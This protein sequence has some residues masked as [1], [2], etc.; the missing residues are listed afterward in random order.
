[1]K[2][3]ALLVAVVLVLV[4]CST[5]ASPV[6]PVR[7]AASASPDAPS[8]SA[9]ITFN[10]ENDGL[11]LV[12]AFDRLIV[13]SGGDVTV[14]LSLHNTRSEELVF[15]EPCDQTFAM[16]VEVPNPVEPIGR[17]WAGIAGAFKTYALE[18]STGS[19]M[20]SSIRT[21]LKTVA[22]S[23]PCHA[24]SRGE[25]VF[26]RQTIA[27]G[28]TY[29]TTLTWS[30]EFVKDLPAGPG[31]FPFSIQVRHNLEA[32]DGGMFEA[33]TLAVD[34]SITILPGGPKAVSAGEALD[35]ALAD[36]EFAAWLAKQP[37][38]SWEHTNLL[39]QPPAVGVDVLPVVP[40][41][42]VELFRAPRNWAIL[43]VDA[44]EGTVLKRM[45]CDI[46]CDR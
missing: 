39:L 11:Q 30:A 34:G 28:D 15:T 3:L 23:S 7:L 1:M 19:P 5:A 6:V 24:H 42:S 29:E 9:A 35:A 43:S 2:L 46:P 14:Q 8:P 16:I 26:G 44:S 25:P 37:R 10:S 32:M 36:S 12:A 45:F 20:E 33:K 40:Y 27:A 21:P 17:D 13:E 38:D 4:A 18:E 31:E 22:K 41:W